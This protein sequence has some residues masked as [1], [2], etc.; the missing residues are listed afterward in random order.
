MQTTDV[1]NL[2]I[3][4]W[5]FVTLVAIFNL[6][7]TEHCYC[8]KGGIYLDIQLL[9]CFLTMLNLIA[10]KWTREISCPLT[11]LVAICA[12]TSLPLFIT[13]AAPQ[14][15][16]SCGVLQ[17]LPLKIAFEACLSIALGHSPLISHMLLVLS[18][19]HYLIVSA[20]VNET[21]G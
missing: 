1:N 10:A 11:L 8:W 2:D 9:S 20:K 16:I 13:I 21:V 5:F 3:S 4:T 17:G 14:S 6:I 18:C 12:R 19:I 7:S 15:I